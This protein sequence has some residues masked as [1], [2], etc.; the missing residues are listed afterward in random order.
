MG[1]GLPDHRIGQMG[2]SSRV[3]RRAPARE[4]GVR[5]IEAAPKNVDWAAL[6]DESPTE[7]LQDPA[8][9]GEDGPATG[10]GIRIVRPMLPVVGEGQLVFHLAWHR[11]DTDVH[12]QRFEQRSVFAVEVGHGARHQGHGPGDAVTGADLQVVIDEVELH[13]EETAVVRHGGG[14][15]PASRRIK[16]DVPPAID[17]R[18]QR[19]AGLPDD[20]KPPLQ[21]VSGV[22]P[23]CQG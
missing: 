2:N 15:E 6:A 17:G 22:I 18:G 5:Q 19:Q 16:G 11:S 23:L 12:A 7:L 3:N 10:G 8:G 13:L 9:L 21:R 4:P 14:G 20:L 1:I